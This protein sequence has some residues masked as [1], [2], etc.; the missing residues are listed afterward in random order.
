MIFKFKCKASGVLIMLGA[1]GDQLLR[2]IGREPAAQGIIEVAAMPAAM[3]AIEA[4]VNAQE[5]AGN[6]REGDQPDG[7]G[8]G[9]EAAIS[10]RRR[11]WPMREMLARAQA[12]GEPVVW[13][14]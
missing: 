13:G 7:A 14:V 3:V 5:A 9:A 2:A 10:L 1:G 8:A 4:A 11:L 6:A 12:A